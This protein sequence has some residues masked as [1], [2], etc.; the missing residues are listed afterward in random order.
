MKNLLDTIRDE[1]KPKCGVVMPISSLGDYSG[2]HWVEVYSVIA[3]AMEKAGFEVNMVSN[4]DESS[5]IQKTIIQNLYSNELVICDVSGKNPNVMFEL[6]MRL[7]FDKATII[8]K[9][10]CTD[11]SFDTAVIEHVGYPRDL[12]YHKIL[13][14]KE[15]LEL[16]AKATYERA[17]ETN[18]STFLKNFGQ[19]TV[20]HLSEIE[21]GYSQFV[22]NELKEIKESIK[23]DKRKL[24]LGTPPDKKN[25]VNVFMERMLN[26]FVNTK[27][28]TRFQLGGQK[29]KEEL[30][31]FIF[32]HPEFDEV[33]LTS[34]ELRMCIDD[35]IPPF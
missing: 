9:D 25:T 2:E 15:K 26:E 20:A 17:K 13:S 31:Q 32:D 23:H 11:F 1:R 7:A 35:A 24:L 28:T 6:G 5:V 19:F 34:T 12:H 8:I 18:Y 29:D 21:V 14:F 33:P 16:K 3:D 10:D 22:L 27:K 30:Y 4:S